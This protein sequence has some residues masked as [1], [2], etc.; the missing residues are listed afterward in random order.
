MLHGVHV[1]H[2]FRGSLRRVVKKWQMPMPGDTRL[3]SVA[4]GTTLL[5]AVGTENLSG[6]RNAMFAVSA[7]S[8]C[9]GQSVKKN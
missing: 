1:N 4:L 5:V 6:D 7:I 3:D 2:V 8:A 9:P